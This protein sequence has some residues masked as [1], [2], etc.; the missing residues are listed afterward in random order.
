MT[1]VSIIIPCWNEEAV[2][3]HLGAKLGEA[4][5]RIE[6]EGDA[7]SV[8]LFD[9]GSADGTLEAMRRV[10]GND[11][12]FAIHPHPTNVNIGGA[13]REGVRL[14]RGDVIVFMDSDCSYDPVQ[15]PELLARIRG[16][17]DVVSA[18][19]YHPE[20]R[21]DGVPRWR[22]GLSRGLSVLYR[23]VAPV[24]LWTYTSMF[25][26]YRREVLE[27]IR[28]RS[29]GFLS[30]TEIVMEAAAAGFTIVEHPTTL[31][32]RQFGASKMRILQVI[33]DHV[34]YIAR[35]VSNGTLRRRVHRARSSRSAAP[36]P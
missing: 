3:D 29:D 8:L 30:C 6:A 10:F 12:R 25:R 33:A 11:P 21:V 26:A 22:L 15:I 27:S 4:L 24:K 28:W 14:V 17:A 7:V 9:N 32:V 19:P 35:V 5:R 23:L 34:R 36:P 16:G 13:L 20:G 31:F 1:H 2:I 18:S